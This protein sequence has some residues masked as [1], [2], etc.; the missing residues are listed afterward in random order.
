ME[1]YLRQYMAMGDHDAFFARCCPPAGRSAHPADRPAPPTAELVALLIR[2][3]EA[4]I[5]AGRQRFDGVQAAAC[6]AALRRSLEPSPARCGGRDPFG[7]SA[8]LESVEDATSC[9]NALV[10]TAAAGASCPDRND[11]VPTTYCA[12]ANPSD[13]AGLCTPRIERGAACRVGDDSCLRGDECVRGHCGARL[14]LG[15]SC[16][17]STDCAGPA[18]CGEAHVCVRAAFAADGA[19]CTNDAECRS[20]HCAEGRCQTA[21]WA[22]GDQVQ[23]PS[24]I[25]YID[26]ALPRSTRGYYSHEDGVHHTMLQVRF[27]IDRRDLL[28][29]TSRLPCRLGPVATAPPEFGTVGTN[30]R[31]WYAP[32]SARRHRGCDYHRGIRHDSFLVDVADPARATVYAAIATE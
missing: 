28:A 26:V 32:E 24:Q 18:R 21:C 16:E 10:G 12:R 7:L 8:T 2:D 25:A 31:T 19:A 1:E 20:D 9:P 30:D 17:L 5:Q 29:L 14:D 22:S 3:V 27:E 13:E 6:I 4:K 15:A 11:C 23:A